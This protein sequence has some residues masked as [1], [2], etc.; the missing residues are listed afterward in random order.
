VEVL[1]ATIQ[2]L[3]SLHSLENQVGQVVAVVL[4]TLLV[5]VLLERVRLIKVLPV[6]LAKALALFTP[7][8]VAVQEPLER[9]V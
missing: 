7:L 1:V 5:V 2:A 4:G 8:V 6:V 9:Q 3:A